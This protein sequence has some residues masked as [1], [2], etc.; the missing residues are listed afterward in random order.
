MSDRIRELSTSAFMALDLRGMARVDFL[1]RAD[2]SECFV[3][4]VNTIPGFT[5]ISMYP[6]LWEATNL[7]LPRLI[8]RLIELALEEHRQRARLKFTYQPKL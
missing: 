2:L 8:D 6:K 4:E 1:A 5:A 7:P 3:N